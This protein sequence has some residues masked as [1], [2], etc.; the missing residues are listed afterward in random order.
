MRTSAIPLALTFATACAPAP[1]YVTTSGL[2]V[3]DPSHLSSADEIESWIQVTTQLAP[4]DPNRVRSVAD[5]VHGATLQIYDYPTV[6]SCNGPGDIGCTAGADMEIAW[7]ACSDPGPSPGI[8][9]HEI[10]HLLGYQHDDRGVGLPWFR[11]A[12]TPSVEDEANKSIC[13]E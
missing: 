8:L 7:R 3:Y 1:D 11:S 9:A 5:V 6:P 4:S 12:D 10:G 2:G 13:G